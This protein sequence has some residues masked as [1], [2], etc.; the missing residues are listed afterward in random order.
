MPWTCTK[1]NF[2]STRLAGSI[3][4]WL[5]VSVPLLA[6]ET[7]KVY[8]LGNSFTWDTQ[9]NNISTATTLPDGI[10]QEI[11]WGIYSGKSLTYI[12]E[13]P[14]ESVKE[15]GLVAYDYYPDPNH[16][17]NFETDLPN[18]HWDMISMQPH[19]YGGGLFIE[20]EIAAAKTVID[21]AR[22]N[23]AN[24]CTTFFILGP[25]A[26]KESPDK[27]GARTYSGNWLSGYS[28]NRLDE[29]RLPNV[30]QAFRGL[31]LDRIKAENPEATVNW[32]PIG[33]V[34]YRLDQELQAGKFEG[35]SGSWDLFDPAGVHLA[36]TNDDGIAGRYIAHITTLSTLWSK[37]PTSIITKYEGVIDPGFKALV[38]EVVWSTVQEFLPTYAVC[39]SAGNPN[40]IPHP[41]LPGALLKSPLYKV[42][43][44]LSDSEE[45]LESET[46]E[47]AT[48]FGDDPIINDPY[49]IDDLDDREAL[50]DASHWTSISYGN[51][52][53]VVD[54]E[55]SFLTEYPIETIEVFPGRY[56]IQP[57][58][59]DGK[60]YFSLQAASRYLYLVINDNKEQPLFLFVDPLETNPPK[61]GDEGVLFYGPGIH[62]IGI[63]F[64]IPESIN[65]VYIDLGAYVRGS[66]YANG[67]SNITVRGR[68]TLSGETHGF[69]SEVNAAI[70]FDGN[71]TNQ[72][73]EGITSIRPI[74]SHIISKGTLHTRN[75]KCF[76]Y[77]LGSDGIEAG[78]NS[79]TEDC[80]FKVNGD[81]VK[82]YNDNQVVRDLV[83]YHQTNGPVFQ[84][85]RSNQSSQNS[86]IERIDVVEDN[87]F[88]TSVNGHAILEWSHNN[89]SGGEQRGHIFEDFRFENGINQ[90]IHI[91]IDEAAGSLDIICRN[92]SIKE[93]EDSSDL[94]ALSPGS[95][96][97]EFENVVV[98]E[99]HIENNDFENSGSSDLQLSFQPLLQGDEPEITLQPSGLLVEP[100]QDLT[101]NAEA[102]GAG[103]LN[104]QWFKDGIP[105]PS[106]TSAFFEF[107]NIASSAEGEYSVEV[108][109]KF[110]TSVSKAAVVSFS[111]LSQNLTFDALPNISPYGESVVELAAESSSG[112]EPTYEVIEGPAT[113][114]GK[115]VTLT[116]YGL[117]TI[118]VSQS[119]N[120]LYAEASN[121]ER[122]FNALSPFNWW[123]IQQ[124][125]PDTDIEYSAGMEDPDKDALSNI[126]E[127]FL[128][129]SPT[130]YDNT[131]IFQPLDDSVDFDIQT[132]QRVT[133]IDGLNVKIEASNN[134]VS[135]FPI[136]KDWLDISETPEGN[137]V[138]KLK[139][140]SLPPT[141]FVRLRLES[142]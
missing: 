132:I 138:Y 27:S 120:D 137:L 16:S 11:G 128:G 20:T 15:V 10:E 122:S 5:C 50:A 68:G 13:N 43:V 42:G 101:L 123:R 59:K 69:D 98:G 83:V 103:A 80:F 119:G 127:Y 17:G 113:I 81:I 37:N 34:L 135:W 92:W 111:Q 104:F 58:I 99:Q 88:G 100:E 90:L 53:Y 3:L 93:V 61:D 108:S 129:T 139:T 30:R 40:L 52:G 112:L 44:K 29:G 2:F 72:Q 75:V 109:N 9:P 14:E 87:E 116:G 28:Q 96:K 54:F 78:I 26:F 57:S 74:K 35:L 66:F 115:V 79:V 24:T 73:I 126:F 140:K 85:G 136:D 7:S 94:L 89:H 36:D 95:I 48:N 31:F 117:I 22:Q 32:I 63:N 125:G 84:F 12:V 49:N 86:L 133:S 141:T 130:V 118:R 107:R 124:L 62:D 41:G 60:A 8:F 76:S 51:N 82:L 1:P 65:T 47:Y 67:R 64:A 55:I 106:A 4:V 91:N 56:E 97:I 114:D 21:T 19:T 45:F 23:P 18:N 46:M 105:L 121:Q 77:N 131:S 110:G 6:A 142:I 38:D 25:W 71:G 102:T 39:E 33:E 70:F 134:M